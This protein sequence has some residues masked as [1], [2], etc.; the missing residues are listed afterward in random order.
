MD[1]P[2]PSGQYVSLFGTGQG[3]VTTSVVTGEAATAD[4]IAY[5][6]EKLTATTN[7][8]PVTAFFA[9]LA[10]SLVGVLQVNTDVP[11]VATKQP[12]GLHVTLG[13]TDSNTVQ[14]WVAP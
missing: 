12:V 1:N 10:P 7:L 6:S 3:T 4:P 8:G 5:T 9:G 14:I 11:S 13:G 2:A